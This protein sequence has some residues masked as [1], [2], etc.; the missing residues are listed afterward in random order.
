MKNNSFENRMILARKRLKIPDE[1]LSM[2]STQDKFPVVMDDGKTIVYIS[3]EKKADETRLKYKLL[4]ESRF[5]TH[6]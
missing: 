3:D 2:G 6:S 5:P 1:R 4:K